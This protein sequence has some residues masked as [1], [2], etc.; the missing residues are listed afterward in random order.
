MLCMAHIEQLAGK[1]HTK[2]GIVC[3]VFGVLCCVLCMAQ[4]EQLAGKVCCKYCAV[5][6]VWHRQNSWYGS[7]VVSTVLCVVYGAD[8]TA[9][10]EG[11]L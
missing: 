5:C 6:C 2:Y 4:T 7:C 1:V 3:C 8:R 9:G 10:R 11:V